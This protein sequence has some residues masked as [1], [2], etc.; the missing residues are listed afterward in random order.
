MF[1]GILFNFFEIL[2][3]LLF[4]NV[5]DDSV[6]QIKVSDNFSITYHLCDSMIS[7]S[8]M[9]FMA[10]QRNCSQE[11]FLS[12]RVFEELIC[13]FNSHKVGKPGFELCLNLRIVKKTQWA[14]LNVIDYRF[15]NSYQKRF[16]LIHQNL[17]YIFIKYD[18]AFNRIER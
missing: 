6:E 16:T 13:V 18:G 9:R 11:S 1:S 15:L 4:Y 14:C 3:F 10:A 17:R 2:N 8:D 5:P 12:K 7:Y